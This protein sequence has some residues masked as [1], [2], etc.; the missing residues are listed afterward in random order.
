[1][2]KIKIRKSIIS[3]ASKID[4]LYAKLINY[5]KKY[6]SNIIDN[7]QVTGN[8]HNINNKDSLLLV[9]TFEKK[10]V[11]F[12]YMIVKKLDDI[13]IHK[14]GFI[15]ALFVE[16]EYRNLGIG[17]LLILNAISWAKQNKIKYLD[18]DVMTEN[19]NAVNFYNKLK[20]KD[21]KKGMRI[22]I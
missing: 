10:I 17:K 13:F 12:I 16:E 14:E 2:E 7:I 6:S 9:A 20:F 15:E 22:E 3:D 4:E 1:M 5:E 8:Y 18:I 21:I 19:K 11:G